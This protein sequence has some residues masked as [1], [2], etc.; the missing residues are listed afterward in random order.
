MKIIEY[1]EAALDV[2]TSVAESLVTTGMYKSPQEA[3]KGLA[4][5]QIERDIAKYRRRIAALQRKYGM[6]FEEFTAHLQG[7]A[8]M[9]EEIDWEE[10]DTARMMLEIREKSREEIEARVAARN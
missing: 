7:R 10:W 5:A 1:D 8:T 6:S 9:A 3:V 2:L 4:L